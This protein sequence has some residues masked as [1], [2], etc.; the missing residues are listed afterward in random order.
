MI[1]NLQKLFFNNPSVSCKLCSSLYGCWGTL[2]NQAKSGFRT[3]DSG[4]NTRQDYRL[5]YRTHVRT[6]DSGKEHM[7]GLKT[8]VENTGQ[9]YRLRYRTY[10]WTTD[11]GREHVRTTDSGREHMS[12]LQTQVENTCQDYRLR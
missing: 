6:T 11:L 1:F 10:V 9:D 2:Q 7:S 8:Q 3:T 4:R 12:G 5:R